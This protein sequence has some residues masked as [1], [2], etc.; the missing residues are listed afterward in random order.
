MGSWEDRCLGFFMVHDGLFAVF[1]FSKFKIAS[2]I[3]QRCL[4]IFCWYGNIQR[5]NDCIYTLYFNIDTTH[6]EYISI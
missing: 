4:A 1:S 3:A 6:T 2:T 5:G